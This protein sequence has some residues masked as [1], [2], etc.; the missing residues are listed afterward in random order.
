MATNRQKNRILKAPP[1]RAAHL[2][3]YHFKPG[4]NANPTG[5]PKDLSREL[6]KQLQDKVPGDP[7]GRTYAQLFISQVISRSIT[8]SDVMAKEI[9]DRVEGRASLSDED[10]AA[11]KPTIS[12]IVLDIPRPDRSAITVKPLQKPA[13][14]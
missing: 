11:N 8:K 2:K 6:R 3:P 13:K 14:D 9:F 10:A 5:R 1:E 12:V 4:N 7:K